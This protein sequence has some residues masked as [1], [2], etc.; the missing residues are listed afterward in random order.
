[1]IYPMDTKCYP[2]YVQEPD[3][4]HC[5][6]GNYFTLSFFFIST[7]TLRLT[8][9][10]RI[11]KENQAES[12]LKTTFVKSNPQP[13]KKERKKS[14]TKTNTQIDK[15]LSNCFFVLSGATD[16]EGKKV[17]S[18]RRKLRL[19]RICY[20]WGMLWCI[21]SLGLCGV[22]R[23]AGA[24]FFAIFCWF[25]VLSGLGWLLGDCWI[26][27]KTA[28]VWAGLAETLP[29]FW[30]CAFQWAAEVKRRF[31]NCFEEENERAD[32]ENRISPY[33]HISVVT[34]SLWLS[35]EYSTF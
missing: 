33:F 16:Q 8:K 21:L 6:F 17:E 1:M 32:A 13:K 4:Q 18:L 31:S 22:P 19:N 34:R 27:D 7:L 9:L 30:H 26:A 2:L 5:S 28:K 3:F 11:S 10:L 24:T 15:K 20:L 12:Q 23:S 14:V 35:G 25:C 29:V